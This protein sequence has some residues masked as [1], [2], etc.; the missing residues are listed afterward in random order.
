[1]FTDNIVKILKKNKIKYFLYENNNGLEKVITSTKE[2]NKETTQSKYDF[3]LIDELRIKGWTWNNIIKELERLG[4][5]T[6]NARNR[7]KNISNL[8][9]IWKLKSKTKEAKK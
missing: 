3:N 6:G 8:Y 5:R 2:K 1:M 9:N 7:T 4:Y